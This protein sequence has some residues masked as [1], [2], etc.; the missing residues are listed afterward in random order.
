MRLKG[1]NMYELFASV[2][3]TYQ[4]A[5]AIKLFGFKSAKFLAESI[6]VSKVNEVD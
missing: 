2:I 3:R 4:F 6:K 5:T 1:K